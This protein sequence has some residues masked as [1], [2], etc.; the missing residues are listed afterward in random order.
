[1]LMT[2]VSVRTVWLQNHYSTRRF[3]SIILCSLFI[4]L[5]T[6]SLTVDVITQ[7]Y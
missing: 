5:N 3:D 1:M 6:R 7:G 4:F 2:T